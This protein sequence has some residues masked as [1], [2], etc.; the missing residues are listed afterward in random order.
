MHVLRIVN[1]HISAWIVLRI[2][3]IACW[4]AGSSG[5]QFGGTLDLIQPDRET[6]GHQCIKETQSMLNFVAVE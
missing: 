1:C 5:R 2:I 4:F 6:E 3:T